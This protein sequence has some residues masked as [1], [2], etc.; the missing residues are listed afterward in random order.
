MTRADLFL[1]PIPGA[2]FAVAEQ[3]GARIDLADQ[4]QEFVSIGMSGQIEILNVTALGDVA[5]AGAKK[6]CPALPGCAQPA[7]WSIGIRIA[8][9]ENRLIL[10]AD[11]SG[12]QHVRGRVLAHHAG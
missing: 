9:E 4:I 11:H 3:N 12:S 8:D 2:F 7:S 6:K 5:S 1:E 10:I